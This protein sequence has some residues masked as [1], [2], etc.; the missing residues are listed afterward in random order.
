MKAAEFAYLGLGSNLGDRRE[1]LVLA[2]ARLA[3]LPGVEL[4]AS[5]RLYRTRPVGGPEGQPDYYNAALKLATRLA[6]EQLLA[7]ALAVEQE[8]GRVRTERWGARCIDID[9]LFCGDREL[10][11]AA[12]QLPHPRLAERGFVLAPLCD[13]A[14]GLRHPQ[15][16]MTLQ[17]LFARPGLADGLECLGTW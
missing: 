6:P 14:P 8:L 13:L 16:G 12:L 7:A 15:L 9:L 17:E 2:R 10:D 11:A 3:A 5:S 1:Q 4:L